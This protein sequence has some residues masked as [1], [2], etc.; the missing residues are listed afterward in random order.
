MSLLLY[1]LSGPMEQGLV[2]DVNASTQ[3]LLSI[4]KQ[5]AADEL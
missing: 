1:P 4:Y 3:N 2:L 5:L